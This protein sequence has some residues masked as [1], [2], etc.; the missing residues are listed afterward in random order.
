MHAYDE[1]GSWLLLWRE[2]CWDCNVLTIACGRRSMRLMR[3]CLPALGMGLQQGRARAELRHL[4]Q[5]Q[6]EAAGSLM[7][8]QPP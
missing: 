1:K 8:L 7:Q 3:R 4:T 6:Q 5:R 2:A